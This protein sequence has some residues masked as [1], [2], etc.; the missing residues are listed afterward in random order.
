MLPDPLGEGFHSLCT[1]RSE[2]RRLWGT[3]D[4][5]RRGEGGSALLPSCRTSEDSPSGRGIGQ[6]SSVSW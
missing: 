1:A 6:G 2:G 3:G 5:H 4:A